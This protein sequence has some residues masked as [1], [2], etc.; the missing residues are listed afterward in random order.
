MLGLSLKLLDAARRDA[1]MR[2]DRTT[3]QLDIGYPDSPL[4]LDL[5]GRGLPAGSRAPDAPCRGAGGQPLRLFHLFGPHWTLLAFESD[6]EISPRS[7]LLIHRV[8]RDIIDD[9]GHIAAA[10]DFE[11]GDVALIRPDGYVGALATS[12]SELDPYLRKVGLL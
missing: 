10:Y 5:R 8:G 2:R 6:A 11:P 4:S 3:Q 1:D 7:G 12:V 9:S